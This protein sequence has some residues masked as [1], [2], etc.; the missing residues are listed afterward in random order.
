[1]YGEDLA[2]V[3]D[4]GFGHI[5]RAGVVALTGRLRRA[6][7]AGG[8]VVDLGCG[9]GIGAAALGE[10]G[11]GDGDAPAGLAALARLA[12]AARDALL[13]GRLLMFDPRHPRSR[14][15][16]GRARRAWR[17]SEDCIVLLAAGE[18]ASTGLLRRHIVT[19]RRD[20][21]TW[22]RREEEHRL[23]PARPLDVRAALAAAGF[24]PVRRLRGDGAGVPFGR[25]HA[26]FVA[27]KPA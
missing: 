1:V 11:Y 4:A 17:E 26:G 23:R 5:A 20:G 7:L 21:E 24:A 8:L 6:G 3:H 13:P 12:A 15:S 19:L 18:D 22:Q 2:H 25:G 9:S 16:V 27:R 14:A 10:A